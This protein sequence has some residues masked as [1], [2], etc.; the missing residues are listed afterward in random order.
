MRK[1]RKHRLSG[2]QLGALARRVWVCE[3]CECFH[4]SQPFACDNLVTDDAQVSGRPKPCNHT[5]FLHFPSTGEA[6]RYAELRLLERAKEIRDLRVHPSFQLHAVAFPVRTV[7]G[8]I[9]RTKLGRCDLDFSYV[10]CNT[11]KEVYE[12]YKGGG[13]VTA[14]S[15]WKHLHCEAEHGIKINIVGG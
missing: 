9:E 6:R 8:H 10:D 2:R 15:R 3:K 5:T 13:G 7:H 14:L 4:Y 11:G 1:K 12:D